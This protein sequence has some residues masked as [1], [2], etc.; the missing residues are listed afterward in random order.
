MSKY[1]KHGTIFDMC[2][3]CDPLL[4]PKPSAPVPGSHSDLRALKDARIYTRCPACHHD[5]ICVNGNNLLCT[6]HECPDPTLIDNVDGHIAALGHELDAVKTQAVKEI[7]EAFAEADAAL[8]VIE[9]IYAQGR[10]REVFPDAESEMWRR[11]EVLMSERRD[12]GGFAKK[13]KRTAACWPQRNENP[14][15]TGSKSPVE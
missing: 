14:E 6:W 7:G 4:T 13:K 1:C 8:D 3:T 11:I 12:V 15:L 2:P 10:G 9:W 5:T